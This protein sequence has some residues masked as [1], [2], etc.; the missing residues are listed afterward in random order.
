MC[1]G[2]CLELVENLGKPFLLSLVLSELMPKIINIEL[3]GDNLMLM[4]VV[5]W[6]WTWNIDILWEILLVILERFLLL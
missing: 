6:R 1:L 3:S 5:V 2:L 4:K